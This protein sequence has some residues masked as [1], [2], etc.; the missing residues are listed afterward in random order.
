MPQN[1]HGSL[2]ITLLL[3]NNLRSSFIRTFL[4]LFYITQ[5]LISLYFKNKFY[6]NKFYNNEF[7]NNGFYNNG[8]Y[9]NEFNSIN[10][11]L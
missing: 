7:Y 6:N 4:Y 11:T 9:N 8:F 10:L 1:V 2:H 5:H 3:D